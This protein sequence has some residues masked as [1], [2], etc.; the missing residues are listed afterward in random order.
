MEVNALTVDRDEA[1]K[2]LRKYREHKAYQTPFDADV[3]RIYKAITEGKV[4]VNAL[5][6]IV[7]HGLTDQHLPKLAIARADEKVCYL[8]DTHGDGAMMAGME[9][10]MG[11]SA[12][13]RWF[14][15]DDGSFPG[16]DKR[17][18]H[19]AMVP[20]IPPDIR[21]RRGIENYHILWEADWTYSPPVDPMLLRRMGKTGDIWL[22]VGAWDLT[23]VERAVMG[24]RQTK[25]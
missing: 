6:E 5:A 11:N 7:K 23:D 16:I 1:V 3:E 18:R 12:R 4:L 10:V 24:M 2:M 22:V 20:H 25:R 15:F 14:K 9:W 17:S 21:P 19:K 8:S 13:S